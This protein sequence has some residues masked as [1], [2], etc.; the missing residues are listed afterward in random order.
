M[1][2]N[3]IILLFWG[4]NEMIKAL[5]QK[6]K[7][8]KGLT[9]IELLAVVVI[10]GIIA[11]I[12]I[13]SIGNLIEKSR[14]DAAK[15]DAVQVLNAAKV[16]TA[17][18]GVPDDGV[19]KETDLNGY[20]ENGNLNPNYTVTVSEGVYTLDGSETAKSK[21]V[22]FTNATIKGINASD[23]TMVVVTP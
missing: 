18:N 23:T 16:Y 20:V 17:S 2:K 15:A 12:A 8:Q 11:A 14:I 5:C 22:T 9:L 10:L 21:T 1:K 7:N 13:P 6:L 3:D 4:E 19:I